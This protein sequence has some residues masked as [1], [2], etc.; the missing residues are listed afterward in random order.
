VDARDR[1]Q[2]REDR[3]GSR[4]PCPVRE[5]LA[6]SAPGEGPEG[7]RRSLE[8]GAEITAP[9]I[10]DISPDV[11]LL[12]SLEPEE[13]AGVVL[14]YLNGLPPDDRGQLNSYNF[15]LP[16][17]VEGY[18]PQRQK[19][20]SRAL[21][22]AWAWL[23]REGMIAPEPGSHGDWVFIT[24]R[25]RQMKSAADLKAYQRAPMLPRKLLHPALPAKVEGPFS[26]GDYDVA[27]FQAFKEVEVAVRTKGRFGPTD[28]GTKLMRDAFHKDTGP[29]RDPSEPDPER[30]ATA[31]LFAGAI[32]RYKN[33]HSHRH[34]P[35]NDPAEAVEL[36]LLASHLLRIVD[37]R[38][39]IP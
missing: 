15:G 7:R 30:E 6:R 14:E 29:L 17:T 1:L 23:E 20:I 33:P 27:V 28:I 35:I 18:P 24:R 9:R 5:A 12:L 19:E 10:F 37:A 16:H 13:L 2:G 38:T 32:G 36:L 34:A 21:M 39:P 4:C 31:H 8:E 11:D 25:G 3:R 26:R 22:E